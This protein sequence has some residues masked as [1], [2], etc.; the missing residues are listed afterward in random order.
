MNS[1]SHT[2][3]RKANFAGLGSFAALRSSNQSSSTHQQQAVGGSRAT[4]PFQ[5]R[6]APSLRVRRVPSLQV[7]QSRFGS[8]GFGATKAKT[9]YGFRVPTAKSLP[10]RLNRPSTSITTSK[11][12]SSSANFSR[13]PA[14][15]GHGFSTKPAI[16]SSRKPLSSKG[17]RIPHLK[18]QSFDSH[19]KRS[20]LT[21]GPR[22]RYRLGH[23]TEDAS[24]SSGKPTSWH[25]RKL[26][27]GYSSMR[28]SPLP[29]RNNAT[30]PLHSRAFGS[31]NNFA[32]M[33]KEGGKDTN[34]FHG[35]NKYK[36]KKVKLL[37]GLMKMPPGFRRFNS[38]YRNVPEKKMNKQSF[39]H[40]GSDEEEEGLAEQMRGR[41]KILR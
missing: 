39:L 40:E 29:R 7:A 18:A 8:T 35:Q 19:G 3:A 25:E 34:S 10:S 20:N 41:P 30:T 38:I 27:T 28:K 22:T 4:T 14:L 13:A 33:E 2:D 23:T 31:K 26:N 37:P 15:S 21:R 24:G 32:A 12:H 6:R 5:I 9:K 1:Y 11:M 36:K 17:Y 16:V